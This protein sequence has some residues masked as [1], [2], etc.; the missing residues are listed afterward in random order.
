MRGNKSMDKFTNYAEIQAEKAENLDF[1]KGIKL[2]YIREKVEA[3]LNHIG[4]DGIF[5]EYT[6]HSIAHVDEMLRIVNWLIPDVTKEEMTYAEW[7]MLTLAIYFHDLGMVVTKKEFDDR[8]HTEFKNYKDRILADTRESEYGEYVKKQDD[9]F[10]Y[11]E[12]VREHHATR[13]R[14]WI[15]GKSD[16]NLGEAETVREEI[17]DMLKKLDTMFKVDLAMVCESHHKDDIDDFTRYK[18]KKKY[19]NTKNEKVNLN[20]I[21]I[22]LRTADLLH[23]TRDR[24]PSVTRRLINI[25]NPVSVLEW[26]KQEAVKAVSP[27]DQ[28]NEDGDVDESKQKNTIEITAYFDGAETAEAYFGLSSYLQYTQKE[29]IR[30]YEIVEKAQ[31]REGAVKYEFPWREID[32]SQIE[33]NGFEKKKLQFTIAQ[34]NILQLLVGHTLY[35]DSSVVVRELVQN[36]IDAVRLQ[37]EYER[38]NNNSYDQGKVWVEWNSHERQLSFWDNGTGMSIQDV[39]NYLLKVGSSKYR[40]ESVKKKFPNFT[41]ISHFGIGILTCFMVAN[42]IDIITSSIEQ[43]EANSINLRKVNGSYLLRKIDKTK[44]DKR[45]EQH[46]TMVRLYIRTD[47]DMSMLEDHLRKWIV[48]PE[49]PVYF[50]IDNNESVRIGYDSLKEILIN[51]LSELGLDVDGKKYAVREKEHGNVTVA[52]AVRHMKYMSDWCLMNTKIRRGQRKSGVLPIGTCVEG[53]RV[54]FSTPGYKNASIL[55]IANIKN[56][57]YQTNVARSALELDASNEILSDIYDVYKEYVQEQ[58][59]ELEKQDYAQSWAASE[60][61]YLMRPLTFDEYSNSRVEPIDEEVLISRLAHLKCLALENNKERYMVSAQDVFE[62][63]EIN[64]FESEMTRAGEYLLKEVKSNA[65]LSQLM[66]V[67][68]EDNLMDGVKNVVCNIDMNNPLHEYALRNKEVSKIKVAHKQRRIQITYSIKNDLWYEFDL[69]DR[70]LLERTLYIPKNNAAIITGLNEEIGLSTFGG[71]Y[72]KSGSE[73][74]DYLISVIKAF[75]M[76]ENEENK[77]LLEAFMS[78]IFDNRMLEVVY[79]ENINTS[80]I[81]RQMLEENFVHVS[82]ELVEKMWSKVDLKEFKD[83]ILTKNYTLYSINNWVRSNESI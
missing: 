16:L 36:G 9:T 77:M 21:A 52:Y 82:N 6:V 72:I 24:T 19:G 76:D 20:Y 83:K 29:L 39:E 63:N 50:S 56:S 2:L 64:I 48:I 55:A 10:L 18:V 78:S 54:E 73:F 38:I 34:E 41:S 5:E 23:I 4:R 81:F 42:D 12:F 71:I 45:I 62:L 31:K 58:M 70:R 80:N 66:E 51:Y 11:Q 35:N 60:G 13:I 8:Y 7:L 25:S 61:R 79:E 44:L 27:K 47:V 67:V 40:D 37:R 22:I 49:I 57:K 1:C 28:R 59:M 69:K 30:C 74:Y 65:T 53:I 75:Q 3:L 68:C 14:Q 46:G 26:E 17:D 15:E 33:V 43:E 32:E